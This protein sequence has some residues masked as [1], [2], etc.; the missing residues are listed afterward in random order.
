MTPIDMTDVASVELHIVNGQHAGAK[1][2]V[3]ASPELRVG[4]NAEND[5]ILADTSILEHHARLRRD[6]QGWQVY[7]L[8]SVLLHD[9]TL[10]APEVWHPVAHALRLGNIW[11]A[12]VPAD[13]C[14]PD[15]QT[16]EQHAQASA[17][18]NLA[19]SLSTATKTA[20]EPVTP[21]LSTP[22]LRPKRRRATSLLLLPALVLP[23]GLLG[24]T[25]HQKATHPLGHAPSAIISPPAPALLKLLQDPRWRG[26][27]AI[28]QADGRAVITGWVP[29]EATLEALS[30]QLTRI[31]P[32]PILRARADDTTREA[33]KAVVAE[34]SPGL[35]VQ[36][37]NHGQITLNGAAADEASVRNV[38]DRLKKQIPELRV[39]VGALEYMP[40]IVLA[41]QQAID[42]GHIEGIRVSWDGRQVQLGGQLAP[43]SEARLYEVLREFDQ[44]YGGAI[45]FEAKLQR[46]LGRYG[47][48]LP[49][50]I[51][52]VIG[53]ASPYIVLADGTLLA[54]GGT[55]QGWR[56]KEVNADALTF[57]APQLLVVK[58]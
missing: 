51:R 6:E 41:L 29:D 27:A 46:N 34:L 44:R 42:A 45:P 30:L 57:D 47:T 14:A 50:A 36:Y 1:I 53:G 2:G 58:R 48:G 16:L 4:A 5:V 20:A 23:A 18:D 15:V 54:P 39:N 24:M 26:L 31:Q 52:S 7:P 35:S 49:F 12:V 28:A 43:S 38:V 21:G 55:Y 33:I 3:A 13:G 11:L 8:G 37:T 22:T 32:R 56:L 40:Q 17:A 10:A 25:A 9:G 19:C